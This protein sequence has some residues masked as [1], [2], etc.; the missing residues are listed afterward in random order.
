MGDFNSSQDDFETFSDNFEMTLV[1][2]VQ[3]G[4]FLTTIIGDFNTKFCNWYSHD[5]TSFQG[6]T[7]ENIT[8]QFGLHHLIS[9]PTHLFQNSSSC[10]NLIFLYHSQKIL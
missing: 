3:K 1:T 4:S 6:S 8:S 5:K 10:I 2:L 7:T 9:E